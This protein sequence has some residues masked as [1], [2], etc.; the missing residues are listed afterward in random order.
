MASVDI[1]C[2][3]NV[4]IENLLTGVGY[5][6]ILSENEINGDVIIEEDGDNY[7]NR[8]AEVCGIRVVNEYYSDTA[9]KIYKS[10]VKFKD[11][12]KQNGKNK[13]RITLNV[14]N[15]FNQYI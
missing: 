10:T 13:S 14:L 9:D 3:K 15:N 2:E 1:I 4:F 12:L 7:P 8:I 6:N 11:G 5:K